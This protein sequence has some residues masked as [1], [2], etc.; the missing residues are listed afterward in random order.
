MKLH[1]LTFFILF[2]LLNLTSIHII[3]ASI[4][5]S[6]IEQH[7]VLI[8]D[9]I[10]QLILQIPSC[11]SKELNADLANNMRVFP[12]QTIERCL[13]TIV[14]QSPQLSSNKTAQDA[15]INACNNYLQA[16][17]SGDVTVDYDGQ[18]SRCGNSK[19]FC[20][21]TVL[22]GI[23]AGYLTVYNNANFGNV[24][25]NGDLIV[26]GCI[27]AD[28]FSPTLQ[29]QL[30]IQA[31]T[32]TLQ[33]PPSSTLNAT[34][35]L[36]DPLYSRV[37][38][39]FDAATPYALKI[40]G[41]D[42]NATIVNANTTA[43]QN[44]TTNVANWRVN[45][46]YSTCTVQ[47]TGSP[48]SQGSNL[49]CGFLTVDQ[50]DRGATLAQADDMQTDNGTIISPD[51]NVYTITS[52]I[53]NGVEQLTT[54]YYYTI[55]NPNVTVTSL[56]NPHE[57]IILN[58]N[59][60]NYL[61]NYNEVFG[62]LFQSLGISSQW[63]ALLNP[64]GLDIITLIW[65]NTVSTWSIE[66]LRHDGR[67]YTY[68][69]NGNVVSDGGFESINSPYFY[70]SGEPVTVNLT[71][72][73]S[74]T[75]EYTD[76]D[77]TRIPYNGSF[78]ITWTINHFSVNGITLFSGNYVYVINNASDFV[79]QNPS[80]TFYI[81]NSIFLNNF[82]ASIGLASTWS[83]ATIAEKMMT[84]TYPNNALQFVLGIVR[85]NGE[86]YY[87]QAGG[88]VTS[89]PGFN[90]E[91]SGYTGNCVNAPITRTA[92]REIPTTKPQQL[93]LIK[94][95]KE[96][97]PLTIPAPKTSADIKGLLY[98][99]IKTVWNKL[100]EKLQHFELYLFGSQAK[101][102]SASG[103]PDID[104]WLVTT[105]MNKASTRDLLDQIVMEVDFKL[106]ITH[107]DQM[108]INNR[109]LAIPFVV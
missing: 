9:S 107:V 38:S 106:D 78:P 22:N 57:P 80:D 90:S 83:A 88:L 21:I 29:E 104:L 59:S 74:V 79:V 61:A 8:P 102:Y 30:C 86:Q 5:L 99:R 33:I 93:R 64:Q 28:C 89:V 103:S 43:I 25:I 42:Y 95:K 1:K 71:A 19:V 11:A 32:Q 48:A 47:C 85:N 3:N 20:N 53:I 87:Y 101:G 109:A 23:T 49:S 41:V 2:L 69:S 96:A 45:S 58:A 73:D 108:V 51:G 40:P 18:V 60:V 72:T 39:V 77:I 100:S 34:L 67:I 105:Q 6:S 12:Q 76:W 52:F 35:Y 68:Y 15:L 4:E 75:C 7:Y 16:I 65:P 17:T 66:V 56:P 26:E 44:L 55:L 27:R 92:K 24:T 63:Q 91:V 97:T 62:S 10:A 54:P 14:L 36:P 94:E 82:F 50:L 98:E 84:V 13:H 70:C 37:I 31:C 46:V 81:N